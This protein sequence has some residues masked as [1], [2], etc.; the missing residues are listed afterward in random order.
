MTTRRA[1]WLLLLIVAALPACF[2]P[3]V[4]AECATGYALCG[5]KCVNITTEADNCGGCGR[6]CGSGVCSNGVCLAGDAG[7]G[8]PGDARLDGT[9]GVFDGAGGERPGDATVN[10]G[11][12]GGVDG[13]AGDGA[14]TTDA[15]VDAPGGAVDAPGG[16]V[17]AAGGAVDAADDRNT[18]I[19]GAG[20]LDAP[21]TGL[22]AINTGVDAPGIGVD[23][24][25]G[26]VDAPIGG[27]VDASDDGAGGAVD[28]VSGAEAGAS[29]G[30]TSDADGEDAGPVCSAGLASCFGRCVDRMT[31][32]DNCGGCGF[33]CASGL[34]GGGMCQAQRAGHLVVI[35]H[36]YVV[37]RA[38]INL[39]VGN[40][41]FLAIGN[42][43]RVLAYEGGASAASISGTNDAIQQVAT[44]V[45]RSW[46][47]TVATDAD[48]A[49]QLP[50][51]DVL[52][53]HAQDVATDAGLQALGTAWATA[54]RA[55]VDA[56]KVIVL[57]DGA[58][59]GHGGTYQILQQAGLFMATGRT[60][61]T[62]ETLTLVSPNDSV[63][64]RVPRTYRAEM[65]SVSFTSMDQTAVVKTSGGVPVVIH[66]VF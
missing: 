9:G 22:D 54:L 64:N 39:L 26:A 7:G 24:P 8:P 61:V 12:D 63:A 16:A 66:A 14:V 42:P 36:D 23:A 17:D 55:H 28:A 38:G 30:S 53:I 49:T 40:A 34:C 27:F 11:M 60:V 21:G 57:L 1:P 2:D 43:V 50:M 51:A 58:A 5:R 4:G 37:G 29:D 52:V 10:G 45:G 6:V 18:M 35:G 46:N 3:I 13:R 15:A 32:P 31:D 47:R 65:S 25:I 62:G 44:D 33:R 41:V 20:G 59:T 56:G 48:L 19:D